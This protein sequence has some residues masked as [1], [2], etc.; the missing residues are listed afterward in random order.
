MKKLD[1]METIFLVKH[2]RKIFIFI[3][4]LAFTLGLKGF[5][6]DNL[7][8]SNATSF[9]HAFVSTLGLF[10]LEWEDYKDSVTL[11]IATI[12]ATIT[13]SFGLALV[14]FSKHFNSLKIWYVQK[15][16]YN[17]FIGLSEQNIKLLENSF[18]KKPSIIIEKDKD[19]AYVAYFKERG[20]AVITLDAYKAIETLDLRNVEHMVIATSNDRKNISLGKRLFDLVEERKHQKIYV[21]IGNRDLSVLFKQNVISNN[22]K[23]VNV[24]AFSLYENMAKELFFKHGILGKQRDIIATSN[25]FSVIVVGNSDLALE[26]VYHLAFLSTLPLENQLTIHLVDADASKFK[27]KIEKTFPNIGDIPHLHV[28]P[29]DVSSES[30]LFYRDTVWESKN[31]TNIYIA[32]QDEEKNLSIAINLQDTTYVKAI[33][34]KRFETKVLF[35]LY[36]N[37][38]LGEELNANQEAFKNFY[39]FGDIQEVST[40]EILFDQELDKIAKL[41]HFDYEGNETISKVEIDEAWRKTTQHKRDANKTQALHIDVKL[42]AFSLERKSSTKSLAE[43]LILNKK[44]LKSNLKNYDAIEKQI[45]DFKL[46]DFPPLHSENLLDRLAKSEHNRWNAFHYLDGWSHKTEKNVEAKEH[47]CLLPLDEFPDEVKLTYKY[48]LASVFN[49]PSYLAHAGF[50]ILELDK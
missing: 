33:G 23:N 9:L 28:R 5:Y 15:K 1:Y 13:T 27:E 45:K 26:L 3:A 14:L 34:H 20:F 35:A 2:Q 12:L 46:E 25:P 22:E 40:K 44:A 29:T 48:D 39:T 49:M 37:M 43:L 19:N 6:Y 8:T 50:E 21:S 11:D 41:I 42:L 38:G 17:L 4:V 10:V 24:L 36:K 30:L 18:P 31:L 7:G 16:S 32:T 47:D